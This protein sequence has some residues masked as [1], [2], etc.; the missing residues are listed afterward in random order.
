MKKAL[1]IILLS[2][3]FF[4]GSD[5]FKQYGFFALMLDEAENNPQIISGTASQRPF[6]AADEFMGF[7]IGVESVFFKPFEGFVYIRCQ[8]RFFTQHFFC[9]TNECIRPQ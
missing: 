7:K 6:K 2:I 4:V 3:H 9:C 8:N 5:S 1:Q